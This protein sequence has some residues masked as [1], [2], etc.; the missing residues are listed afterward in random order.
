MHNTDGVHFHCAIKLK[1][2]SRWVSRRRKLKDVY[3]IDVDFLAFHTNYYDAMSYVCKFDKHVAFSNN[4]MDMSKH[5]P[6]TSAAT[7]ARQLKNA[8]STSSSKSS[9]T[10]K[11]AK[12]G[13]DKKPPRLDNTQVCEIIVKNKIHTDEQLG[14]FAT[15]QKRLSKDD[16]MRWF[17]NHPAKR[18][19]TDVI[20]T[21]WTLANAEETI[22]RESIPRMDILREVLKWDHHH[23]T[24]MNKTCTGEWLR[25][26]VEVLQNNNISVE[27]FAQRVR[28]AL[29]QGRSKKNNI[30]DC[31]GDKSCKKFSFH[32]S[33][34]D[35]P[36][37]F[38]PF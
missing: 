1:S 32:A 8:P 27:W 14:A 4:H 11:T 22:D 28:N 17:T 6:Q 3:D 9:S 26:A 33:H 29:T 7:R 21:A 34:L 2:C 10:S 24:I 19:R 20:A 35:I 13:R 12:S 5:A 30:N 15:T 38:M 25:A 18:S 36:L 31:W 23:D 37:F 16:L